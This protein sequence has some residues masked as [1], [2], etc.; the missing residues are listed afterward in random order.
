V[1]GEGAM[2]GDASI[3]A[4]PMRA[5][6]G[7]ATALIRSTLR[8]GAIIVTAE[9]FGLKPATATFQSQPFQIPIA[10]GAR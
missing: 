10:A 9:S 5:E 8:V 7:I 1:T 4:N 3:F 6:A 2:I